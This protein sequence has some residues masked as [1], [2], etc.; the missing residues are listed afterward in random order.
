MTDPETSDSPQA[1]A[2][3]GLA[4]PDRND[5]PTDNRPLSP[6]ARRALAEAEARRRD[7]NAETIDPAGR[8][9]ELNGRDGPEPVR[10]G[11]WEKNGLISDF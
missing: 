2:P 1:A 9:T 11:D 6:A 8:P 10:Y 7:R 5:A 4:D 3:D